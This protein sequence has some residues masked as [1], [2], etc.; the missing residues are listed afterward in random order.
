MGLVETFFYCLNAGIGYYVLGAVDLGGTIF[1]HIFG[2][3]FGL[4][5]TYALHNQEKEEK[6]SYKKG[7]SYTSVLFGMIGTIFL[8]M[9]WPSFNAALGTGEQ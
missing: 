7:F 2:A 9:F 8:W 1:I 4:A 3:Y 6:S 5:C